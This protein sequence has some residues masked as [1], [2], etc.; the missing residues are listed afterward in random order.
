[1]SEIAI[2]EQLPKIT[3]KI[4]EIGEN[5][6]KRLADLNLDELVCN[7]ETRKEATDLRATLNKEK[8][9]FE[10][11]KKAIIEKVSVPLKK[12]KEA[13]NTEIKDR[14]DEAITL[15]DT[16]IELV[17]VGIKEETKLKMVDFFEEYRKSKNISEDY[18][19]FED[20][21][22]KLGIT[23]LTAKGDL[24]KKVK[25]E[26]K[27]AVNTFATC[28]ETIKTMENSDEILVEYLKTK[29]LSQAIKE[30]NDRHMILNQVQRDYEIT[31]EITKQEEQTI[32]RVEEV[33]Q[34]PVEE[35]IDGQMSIEDFSEDGQVIDNEIY[36]MTFT[37]KG[38][39]E[40]LKE[41]KLYL[42]KEGFYNE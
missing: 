33:L 9:E 17:E 25:D 24:V 22:I 35:P 18:L 29:D 8:K 20:L 4:K 14:Y 11:Q 6:D 37:V 3:D 1:M 36:E 30:V 13:Y 38:T 2:I 19:K 32:E 12:F 7:E 40:K 41:L 16:K 39:I 23:Q 15:L 27:D 21:G 42:I 26:I 31:Q 5:L 28:I 34:A 10:M